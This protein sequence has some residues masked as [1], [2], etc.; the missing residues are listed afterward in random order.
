[1]GAIDFK[2]A[3]AVRLQDGL[4]GFFFLLARLLVI[5]AEQEFGQHIE[6]TEDDKEQIEVKTL[7]I[8]GRDGNIKINAAADEGN[9]N[10]E[11]GAH[12]GTALLHGHFLLICCKKLLSSYHTC[13]ALAREKGWRLFGEI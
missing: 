10:T 13:P 1:M 6:D 12:H 7:G 9:K 3:L 11:Q 5:A 4:L 2:T 8:E